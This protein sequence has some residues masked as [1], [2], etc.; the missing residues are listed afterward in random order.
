MTLLSLSGIEVTSLQHMA[1]SL[2]ISFQAFVISFLQVPSL[3]LAPVPD[4]MVLGVEVAILLDH[5][6]EVSVINLPQVLFPLTVS[7]YSCKA[8]LAKATLLM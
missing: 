6:R 8:Q 2:S 4:H 5:G 3:L 1:L 7:L